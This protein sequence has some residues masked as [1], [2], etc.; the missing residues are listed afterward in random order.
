M[1]IVR[2]LS[3]AFALFVLVLFLTLS[4]G[5]SYVRTKSNDLP[6]VSSVLNYKPEL[7]SNINNSL[8]EKITT[9]GSTRRKYV[10]YNLIP[11]VMINAII[12]A[13]DKN[14]W[15]HNGY[16]PIAIIKATIT[17]I[18]YRQGKRSIGGSTITQQVVKNLVLS[19]AFSIER[20]VKEA[21]LSVEIE[22]L[23]TK[24]K[25]LEIYLNDIYLGNGVYGI[26]EASE[27]Y[28]GKKISDIN[29]PEAAFLAGVPKAPSR[30][31]VSYE[32]AVERRSYVLKQMLENGYINE[33]RFNWANSY[34]LPIPINKSSSDKSD[35]SHYVGTSIDDLVKYFDLNEFRTNSYDITLA[36]QPNIQEIAVQSLRSSLLEYMYRQEDFL[37]PIIGVNLLNLD[38]YSTANF[39][40]GKV[41]SSDILQDIK[42]LQ[43]YKISSKSLKWVEKSYNLEI[44]DYVYFLR[45]D[46]EVDIVQLP[47]VQGAVV[48]MDS[49]TGFVYSLSGAFDENTSDFNRATMAKRQPGS[50]LKPFVYALA[51]ENGWTPASPVLDSSIAYNMSDDEVWRPKDHGNTDRG[52]T[53]L[54]SGLEYSRNTVTLRLFEDIGFNA[55]NALMKQLNIYSTPSTELS[56]IL[57][58]KEVDLLKLVSAYSVFANPKGTKLDPIFV[59]KVTKDDFEWINPSIDK[60]IKNNIPTFDLITNYQIRSMLNGVTQYGT[61]WQTFDGFE[62]ETF[63]K[64]GTSN[65]A[66]DT[67]YIGFNENV[68][69]GAYV[70]L[71]NPEPL[72]KGETG[73]KTAAPIVKSIFEKLPDALMKNNYK[74][75]DGAKIVEI[76]PDTGVPT[77]GGFPEIFRR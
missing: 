68:I 41:V 63:G 3:S 40:I 18:L 39:S 73:G 44:D 57:G 71:D 25:I 1:N 43:N 55:F 24:E 36:L 51:L 48:V 11:P 27:V 66:K 21:L 61:A 8:N 9:L 64:T 30:Y 54:R 74:F 6:S 12:S 72:G 58:T 28:F 65:S 49:K 10:E 50:L 7:Y 38:K 42:T 77:K 22:K 23:T 70:G 31:S 33:E 53:T 35:Y 29:L 13:E 20:K 34:E 62:H 52:F 5:S 17:N 76:D 37:G 56:V 2:I 19:D 15:G 69:I 26:G 16:D 47:N 75:P 60:N 32:A 46:S 4:V 14:F 45:N 59:K 67:W